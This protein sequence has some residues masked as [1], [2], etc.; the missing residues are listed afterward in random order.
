MEFETV[1]GQ[2]PR[3]VAKKEARG[4]WEKLKPAQ[5]EAA[6]AALPLHVEFWAD[7]EPQ[8]IPHFATWI[9]AERWEDELTVKGVDVQALMRA[10]A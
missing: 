1:W 6:A 8:Y 4:A 3:K 9:R 7:R 2:Y 5:K 10:I